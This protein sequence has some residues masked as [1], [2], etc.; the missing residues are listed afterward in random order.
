M[1]QKNL[2]DLKKLSYFPEVGPFEHLYCERAHSTVA[3]ALHKVH[4]K[5]VCRLTK[6]I[7][8]LKVF[9]IDWSFSLQL[10]V[11]DD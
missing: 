2:E 8:T 5:I 6:D 7:R 1:K 9:G 10:I 3:T 4:S 11:L